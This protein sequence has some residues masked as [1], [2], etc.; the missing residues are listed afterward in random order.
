MRFLLINGYM[1]LSYPVEV[2]RF[3]RTTK[4]KTVNLIVYCSP[5]ELQAALI[6]LGTAS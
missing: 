6:K 4:S 2:E 3:N 1:P 5:D